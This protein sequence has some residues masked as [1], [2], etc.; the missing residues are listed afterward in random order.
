[1]VV[2]LAYNSVDDNIKF[3]MN[4]IIELLT[5]YKMPKEN[6]NIFYFA[7][8]AGAIFF[9]DW[10]LDKKGLVAKPFKFV[11]GTKTLGLGFVFEENEFL[12]AELLKV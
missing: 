6:S 11:E 2:N 10:I 5:E 8:G 9:C 12:T 7:D 1:M 3:V 4:L